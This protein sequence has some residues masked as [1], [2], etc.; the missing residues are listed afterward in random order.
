MGIVAVAGGTGQLGRTIVEE[1]LKR[2]GQEVI[3]LGRKAIPLMRYYI[4]KANK[5][6]Q[7]DDAKAKEIGARIVAIDYNNTSSIVST[8]EENKV[9]TVIAVLNLMGGIEPELALISAADQSKTTKR[10]IPSCWGVKCSP[11][12][13][14]I[15]PLD[16]AKLALLHAVEATSLDSTSVINGMFMDYYAPPGIKT[17]F[18]PLAFVLDM[19]NNVAAIPGSGDVPVV[20]TYTFDVGRMA[21]ALLTLPKWSKFYYIIGDR[22]TWNQVIQMAEETKAVKFDVKHDSVEML[23]KGQVTELP[24]HIHLYPFF[25]KEQL[26]G[27]LSSL[28]I[29]FD[30]GGFDLKPAKGESLNEIFPEVKLTSMKDIIGAW[31]GK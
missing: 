2:G 14:A 23:K 3:I 6:R 18:P 15:S 24:S 20:F 17:Y 10:Y 16:A 11:E 29:L 28:G 25:P 26:Q 8:L 19:A 27:A 13:A 31:K 5:N 12:I 21:A 22:A 7:K 1:I 30:N 9:E 4:T